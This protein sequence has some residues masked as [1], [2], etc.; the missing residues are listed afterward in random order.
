M[1]VESLEFTRPG[2]KGKTGKLWRVLFVKIFQC[3]QLWQAWKSYDCLLIKKSSLFFPWNVFKLTCFWLYFISW[4]FLPS[5][6]CHE[7][8]ARK[9]SLR[10]LFIQW[11][12]NLLRFMSSTWVFLAMKRSFY[13]Y[14][15]CYRCFPI[16][17]Q[18]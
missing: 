12:S 17:L 15:F 2:S 6:N 10:R 11:K 8:C 9:G 13:C 16:M 7:F 3:F 5:G 4:P 14:C 18:D 1:Q